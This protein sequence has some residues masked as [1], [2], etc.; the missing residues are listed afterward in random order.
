MEVQIFGI[1]KNQDVRKALRFFSERR[2]PV[3]FVNLRERAASRGELQRF[4]Q[5][6]GVGALIDRNSRRYSELG[7]GATRHDDAHWLK[8]L[9]DEPL[10]LVM[11]LT[12]FEHKV[13]VGLA[14]A[15]WESWVGKR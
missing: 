15:E 7:L 14:T 12:R 13:T 5:K 4:A 8:I 6:L 10:V 11:P 9:I 3:H 2:V 1:Q